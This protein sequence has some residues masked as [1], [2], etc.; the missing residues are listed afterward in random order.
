MLESSGSIGT[1]IGPTGLSILDNSRRIRWFR[2]ISGSNPYAAQ[3]IYLPEDTG[4]TADHDGGYTIAASE[5]VLWALDGS[6][7]WAAADIV[8]GFPNPH[9][10]G[11]VG[12][13][14]DGSGW[15]AVLA[16]HNLTG[17]VGSSNSGTLPGGGTSQ[18][19][20]NKSKIFN[21]GA[22][23]VNGGVEVPTYIDFRFPFQGQQYYRCSIFTREAYSTITQNTLPSNSTIHMVIGEKGESG[24]NTFATGSFSLF[25]PDR[26]TGFAWSY[27]N[28]FNESFSIPCRMNSFAQTGEEPENLNSWQTGRFVI[29]NGGSWPGHPSY[30]TIGSSGTLYVGINRAFD[31]DEVPLVAGGIVYGWQRVVSVPVGPPPAVSPPIVPPVVPPV[32]PPPPIL[33]PVSPPTQDVQ[34]IGNPQYL[35]APASPPPPVAI[36]G[37]AVE[38]RTDLHFWK[39]FGRLIRFSPDGNAWEIKVDNA[40]T[41]TASALSITPGEA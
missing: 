4:T 34:L 33:P 30:C 2:I 17:V 23:Y 21:D 13:K 11:F 8:V 40:G 25:N 38:A 7:T 16:D 18:N 10:L 12:I 19:M 3:E 27:G 32:S 29:F 39:V 37:Q 20:G 9:G 6:T 24:L 1:E 35:A 36:G 15:S 31:V 41:I 26:K 5:S 14:A 22:I 28:G